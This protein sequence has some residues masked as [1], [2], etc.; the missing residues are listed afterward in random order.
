MG[1]SYRKNNRKIPDE[2]ECAD[3]AHSASANREEQRKQV[4]L[5]TNLVEKMSINWGMG[6]T[7]AEKRRKME[8]IS[9]E[10]ENSHGSNRIARNLG[11]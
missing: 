7:T 6:H 11:V 3:P 9:G 1:E 5:Y 10:G 2:S 8:E 4:R